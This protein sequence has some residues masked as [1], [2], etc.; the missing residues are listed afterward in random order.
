M[1]V[2]SSD[3]LV[4]SGVSLLNPQRS[5]FRVMRLFLNMCTDT[6][7]FARIIILRPSNSSSKKGSLSKPIL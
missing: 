6:S 3:L 1:K 5:L 4:T 2:N 7:A